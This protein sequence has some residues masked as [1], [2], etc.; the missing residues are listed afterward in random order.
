MTAR[1]SPNGEAHLDSD[2]DPPLAAP[3]KHP[4]QDRLFSQP[5]RLRLPRP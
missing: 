5:W 4:K 2:L 3:D 1:D